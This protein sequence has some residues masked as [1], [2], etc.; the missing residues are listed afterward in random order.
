MWTEEEIHDISRENG[1]GRGVKV[2]KKRP[3]KY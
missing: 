3:R 2:Y 1:F